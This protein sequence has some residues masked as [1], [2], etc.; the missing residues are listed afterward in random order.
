MLGSECVSKQNQNYTETW[1]KKEKHLGTQDVHRENRR[2]VQ[3]LENNN[4]VNIVW[5]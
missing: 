2:N 4:K 5:N 3:H 1:N